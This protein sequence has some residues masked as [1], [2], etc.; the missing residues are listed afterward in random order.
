MDDTLK[1]LLSAENA[2][3]ELVETA[4]KESEHLVQT[5]LHEAH[6]QEER[7]QAHVPEMRASY[8]EKADQRAA[9]TVAEM[10]RRFHERFDQLRK[11]A[12]AHEESALDAAFHELLGAGKK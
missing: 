7:F 8:I 12:E 5:A 9:Q 6:L 10:E 11:D 4:Q 2:A 3:R 1:Q